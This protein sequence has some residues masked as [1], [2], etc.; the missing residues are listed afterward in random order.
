MKPAHV[1]PKAEAEADEA[2]EWYWARSESAALGFHTELR[3]A[4]NAL[5]RPPGMGAP[6]LQGTRRMPLDRYPFFVVYRELPRKIQ[7][8]AVAHAKRRPD[9]WRRI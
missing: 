3:E 5:R 2:F 1:H 7:V 8:V 6:Y 9:Y 4:F